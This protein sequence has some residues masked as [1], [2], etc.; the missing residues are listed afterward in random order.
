VFSTVS[1]DEFRA[2][3]RLFPSGVTVVTRRMKDGRPYGMTVSSFTSVSLDPPLILV[4]IDKNA[5]FINDLPRGLPI[6]VNVLS[7]K[8]QELAV[9]FAGRREEDRFAGLDWDLGWNG[10]PLL[11]GVV[12]TFVCAVDQVVEGGDHLILIAGVRDVNT[13]EGGALVW[14]QRGYHCLPAP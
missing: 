7:E 2:A 13:Y 6:A 3:C 11:G 1:A 8:Q 5:A 12:A 14:C 4:C 10:V 9:R